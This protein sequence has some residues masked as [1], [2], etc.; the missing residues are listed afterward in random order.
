MLTLNPTGKGDWIAYSLTNGFF[1][2]RHRGTSADCVA[3]VLQHATPP[4]YVKHSIDLPAR[5]DALAT[6]RQSL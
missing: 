2:V 4:L 3:A 1:E 6:K 5:L